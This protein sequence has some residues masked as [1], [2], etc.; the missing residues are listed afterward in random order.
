LREELDLLLRAVVRV[1]TSIQNDKT[2]QIGKTHFILEQ[3]YPNP[4]SFNTSFPFHQRISGVISFKIGD[5]QGRIIKNLGQYD[6]LPAEYDFLKWD[7]TNQGGMQVASGM[8]FIIMDTPEGKH[9]KK[10]ILQK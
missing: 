10:V 6:L 9:I 7:G 2:N 8:Y 5:S 3:N 4:F 1:D